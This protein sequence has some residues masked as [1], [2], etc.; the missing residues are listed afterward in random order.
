M[1]RPRDEPRDDTDPVSYGYLHGDN[2][3]TGAL[4]TV[5]DDALNARCL[6]QAQQGWQA[7]I[8]A[9]CWQIQRPSDCSALA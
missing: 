5:E 8:K 1:P 2:A 4:T 3:S 6:A 9:L 7:V